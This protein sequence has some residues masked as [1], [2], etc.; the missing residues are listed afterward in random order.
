MTELHDNDA[1]Q[2]TLRKLAVP[3]AVSVV[4]A[5]AGL[6]LSKNP[7]RLRGAMPD[8]PDLDVADFR[9]DLKNKLESVRGK[10]GSGGRDA[11]SRGFD[12][13]KLETRRNERAKRRADR[14][15]RSK[16]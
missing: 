7:K 14:R 8:L 10:V 2:G 13:R 16:T 9:D 12:A 1:W 3:A 6:L 15:Q 4:G 11:G 5:A